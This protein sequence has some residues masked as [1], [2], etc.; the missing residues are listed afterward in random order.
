MPLVY[1]SSPYTA[2]TP[3][4]VAANI[5][6]AVA[7]GQHVRAMGGIPIVPHVAVL[8]FGVAPAECWDQAMRECLAL[9]AVCDVVLMCEGW[10]A[11]RGC[12]EEQAIA[13]NTAMHVC[14]SVADLMGF[15][16]RAA[17]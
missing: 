7:M 12:C 10:E 11:S 1:V 5:K 14:Y 15:L 6:K 16:E 2:A 4:K 13:E 8:D 17:A 9:M 3:K